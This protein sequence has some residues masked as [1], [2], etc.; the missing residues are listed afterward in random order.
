MTD[1]GFKEKAHV[2]I[3]AL[4]DDATWDDLLREVYVHRSIEA[5]QA[6]G[7]AGRVTDVEDVRESF[8][9]PR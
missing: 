8:G 1:S 6:D 4:P 5:G 3:D 2:L 9:L 7:A